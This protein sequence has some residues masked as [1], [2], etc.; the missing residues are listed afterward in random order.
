[1][2]LFFPQPFSSGA[3][4]YMGHLRVALGWP[5]LIVAAAGIAW[6]VFRAVRDRE[7]AKWAMVIVFPLAYFHLF[8]TKHLNY[9]RY[10][11]PIL[12]FLCLIMAVLM[13]DI[14]GWISR[15]RQ[16]EWF[17]AVAAGGFAAI[18]LFHPVVAGVT[19]PMQ[20]GQR[21]TQDVAYT[22]IR[23]F[24]PQGS[25]V[26]V[27][28]SVMR[29]PE[30]MYRAVDI[31]DLSRRS[32]QQ[33]LASGITFFVASSDS[34]GPVFAKPAEYA[35]AYKAYQRLFNQESEC[36]PAVEPTATL[37]GPQIRILP[38]CCPTSPAALISSSRLTRQSAEGRFRP[39]AGTTEAALRRLRS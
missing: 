39:D 2:T 22:K 8:A 7:F 14:L 10:L 19:W 38:S 33:Y 6:G 20:H 23:E 32:R 26:A 11:L 37:P 35:D 18:V 15:L 16:P 12:P 34:F 9:A 3:A 29:L 25:G 13:T 31:R 5:G 27:E 1:M 4:I 30:P 24:I 28:R 21:T 17:R 36:L